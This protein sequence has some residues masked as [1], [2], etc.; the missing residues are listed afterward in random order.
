MR[1]NSINKYREIVTSLNVSYHTSSP[2][3]IITMF[4]TYMLFVIFFV[5]RTIMIV[6]NKN[7]M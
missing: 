2:C 5:D 3:L 6:D 4:A 7:L 1:P